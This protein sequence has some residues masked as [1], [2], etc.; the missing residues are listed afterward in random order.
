MKTHIFHY[1]LSMEREPVPGILTFSEDGTIRSES[2]GKVLLT[3]SAND[4]EEVLVKA[5]V[6]CGIVYAKMKSGPADDVILCRFSMSGLKPSGDYCKI[7]NYY[8][9]TGVAAIPD[10]VEK[11]VC[12]KC[13]LPLIKEVSV[14]L[15]CYNKLSVLWRCFTFLKHT[16]TRSYLHCLCLCFPVC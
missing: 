1:D 16:K 2:E 11:Q 6:G 8:I 7:V 12:E 9:T 5:G 3:L 4:M 14:C 13:G 10:E 15:F